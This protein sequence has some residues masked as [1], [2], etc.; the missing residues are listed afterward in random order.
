MGGPSKSIDGPA[1][2]SAARGRGERA[3]QDRIVVLFP[4]ALG[5][6]LCCWPALDGLRH[7]SGAVL[8]LAARD[9]WFDA[10]PDGAFT[11]LSIERREITDLFGSGRLGSATRSL[12]A[13]CTRVESWTGHGDENFARRLA[14]ASGAAVAVH[15]F[16]DFRPGEHASAYYARC[17]GVAPRMRQLPVRRDAAEWAAAFWDRHHLGSDVLVVHPGS[18]SAR[19]NWEGMGEAAAAWRSS[20]GQVVALIGPAEGASTLVPHEAVLRDEGLDRVAAVLALSP[21]YLGNDSGISHLAGMVG[22]RGVALFGASDPAV[23]RPL[24]GS[25]RVLH[26]PDA[27]VHCSSERFCTHRLSVTEVIDAVRAAQ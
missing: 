13:G 26:V 25:V 10:L 24:G 27:C 1:A 23:W 4:G 18:G 21:R 5:D 17:V 7:A 11:R 8:T 3:A 15:P 20:G 16:R 9:A 6:V 12:F 14:E 22:A 19:K 2:S